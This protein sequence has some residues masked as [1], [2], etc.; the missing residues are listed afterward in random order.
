MHTLRPFQK[1]AL[2]ELSRPGHVLCVAPTGSGKSLIYER[3]AQKPGRRTLLVTPLVALARQQHARL[4]AAAPIATLG[5]GT[6][7]EGPPPEHRPGI[8]IVSPEKLLC[9]VNLAALQR[10]SPDFLVVDECHCLWEWGDRFRPAFKKIPELVRDGKIASSLWLTATMPPEARE[11][12]RQ[13]LAPEPL[14]ELGGFDLPERLHL[15]VARVPWRERA[16]AL[17]GWVL[18]QRDPGIVFAPTRESTLRLSRLLRASGREAVAYHAGMGAEERRAI[19][20]RVAR[21]LPDAIVA[22]SAFGMGMDYPGLRWSAMWQAP[23]SLLAFAQAIG[24]VGRDPSHPARALALWEE[25]DFRLLE[26]TLQGSSRRKQQFEQ[27][28]EYFARRACRVSGLRAYF[29]GRRGGRLDG[30]GC[31]RCNFCAAGERS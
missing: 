31:G 15:T 13:A 8:W 27:T 3:A 23:Q 11:D 26:W 25:D 24:R 2:D 21:E 28:R 14:R 30:K 1:E 9:P 12:L 20:A 10:W 6:P 7:S 19:E 16:E 5:A 18:Q 22:T 29:D 4:N 17:H